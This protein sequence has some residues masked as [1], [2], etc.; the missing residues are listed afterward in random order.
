LES[1]QIAYFKNHVFQSAIFAT[2]L[3]SQPSKQ[4]IR[5][6]FGLQSELAFNGQHLISPLQMRADHKLTIPQIRAFPSP[7]FSDL[8]NSGSVYGS[9]GLCSIENS[10]SICPDRW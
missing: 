5:A 9:A 3:R 8:P 4:P 7:G 10:W 6:I 2:Q 1:T